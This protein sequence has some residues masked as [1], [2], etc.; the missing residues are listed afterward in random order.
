MLMRCSA[1]VA[2]KLAKK[3]SQCSHV[4]SSAI[5]VP[6]RREGRRTCVADCAAK[7]LKHAL[8]ACM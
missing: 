1:V 4:R 3:R 7:H 2:G 5:A 6:S 8:K